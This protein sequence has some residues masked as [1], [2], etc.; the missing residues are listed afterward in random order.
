MALVVSM[1]CRKHVKTNLFFSRRH[2]IIEPLQHALVVIHE[3]SGLPWWS[4]FFLSAVCVRS[5]MLP[6][7]YKQLHA[8]ANLR[9]AMPEI[10]YL[11]ALLKRKNKSS[12]KSEQVDNIKIFASGARASLRLHDVK[13]SH[14][15]ATPFLQIPIFACVIMSIRGLVDAGGFGLDVGG[16][17]PFLDLT[18]ADSSLCLPLMA[19]TSTYLN[20][21]LSMGNYFN[22]QK[23]KESTTAVVDIKSGSEENDGS[24]SQTVNHNDL[25][26]GAPRDESDKGKSVQE[27]AASQPPGFLL[28]FKDVMQTGMIIG[29]PLIATLPTGAFIFWLTSSAL[30]TAQITATRNEEFRKRIGLNK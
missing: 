20:L 27:E 10:S 9:K 21:E 17:G 15:I 5:L 6:V 3:T 13:L 14:L 23:Q 1:Q 7:V 19:V 18:V 22:K 12:D 29:L 26:P 25:H 11:N 2:F 4:T 16:F 8:G 30:T 24:G 28:I